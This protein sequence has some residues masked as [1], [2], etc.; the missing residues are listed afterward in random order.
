MTKQELRAEKRARAILKLQR[1]RISVIICYAVLVVLGIFGITIFAITSHERVVKAQ[2]SAMTAS[3]NVQLDLNLNSFLSRMERVGTLAF[4]VDDAYTYDATKPGDE[5]EDINTEKAISDQLY[6]LC[7]LENFVDY[8]IVYANGHTVGKVSNGTTA[9]FGE[10]LYDTLAASISRERTNDGW[11]TG[12][13]D[14]YERIYYVKRIHE[15]ALLVLSF[16]TAELESVFDNPE[17]MSDMTIRLIDNDKNIIYSSQ[18]DERGTALP[19]DVDERVESLTAA[20]RLDGTYLTTV[21]TSN[22]GWRIICTIPTSV[23]LKDS[24]RNRQFIFIAAAV[25]TLIALVICLVLTSRMTDPM[26]FIADN[27]SA[28][29]LKDDDDAAPAPAPMQDQR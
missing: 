1:M 14:N 23:I 18:K 26:A 11:S 16:Y 24:I 8:G 12:Y 5:Y 10:T 27:F 20:A 7:M 13:E 25:I 6:K 28:S 17:T 19:A 21:N 22:V 15:N 3:L 2:A 29:D 9:L 4:S